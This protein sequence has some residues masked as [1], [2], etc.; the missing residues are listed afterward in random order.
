M[1]LETELLAKLRAELIAEHEITSEVR[2][3]VGGLAVGLGVYLWVFVSYTG[4][5]FSRGLAQNQHPVRDIAGAVRRIASDVRHASSEN[6]TGDET[7]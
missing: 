4:R 7:R 6:S 1:T 5:Y 2:E 3:T